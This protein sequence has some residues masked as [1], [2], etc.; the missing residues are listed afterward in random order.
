MKTQPANDNIVLTTLLFAGTNPQTFD[1]LQL[2]FIEY[3]SG[4]WEYFVCGLVRGKKVEVSFQ[5]YVRALKFCKQELK[6]NGRLE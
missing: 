4:A 1:K 3:E 2:D 6:Q 5:S